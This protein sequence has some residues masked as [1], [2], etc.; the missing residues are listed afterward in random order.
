M[1]EDNKIDN[2]AENL[3]GKAKEFGG[4]VTGDSHLEAEG[5]TDQLKAGIKDKVE[6]IKG[7]VS[8][9]TDSLKN[10]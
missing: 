4:K 6:D 10:D 3:A 5:K 2:G 9:V 7:A 1:A 8:G